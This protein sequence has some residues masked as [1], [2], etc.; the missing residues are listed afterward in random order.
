M[1][2]DIVTYGFNERGFF[3][4]FGNVRELRDRSKL[5]TLLDQLED[6]FGHGIFEKRI[7]LNDYG[8][9]RVTIIFDGDEWFA[10]EERADRLERML[11]WLV[12][13]LSVEELRYLRVVPITVDAAS[14]SID[15]LIEGL[16]EQFDEFVKAD[17]RLRGKGRT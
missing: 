15:Q 7:D 17:S 3:Q 9:A 2:R 16:T 10:R 13:K 6:W 8:Q 4:E 5:Y 1:P 14:L 12:L 11:K